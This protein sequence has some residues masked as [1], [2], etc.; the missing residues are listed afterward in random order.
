MATTFYFPSDSWK[1]APISPSRHSSWDVSRPDFFR[2]RPWSTATSESFARPSLG[3]SDGNGG[4]YAGSNP[5]QECAQQWVWGPI[6][7]A[8]V[9]SQTMTVGFMGRH[10]TVWG[11]HWLRA[12]VWIAKPDGT[13][14]GTV[15]NATDNTL[16]ANLNSYPAFSYSSRFATGTSGLSTVNAL[17]GDYVVI[18]IGFENESGSTMNSYFQLGDGN[19]SNITSSDSGTNRNPFLTFGS[20]T[21]QLQLLAGTRFYLPSAGV[22]PL[23]SLA[24][25]SGWFT[26]PTPALRFPMYTTKQTTALTSQAESTG[27]A[28]KE[29]CVFQYVSEPIVGMTFA[30]DDFIRG[31]MRSQEQSISRNIF[32]ASIVYVVSNDGGTIRGTII[33]DSFGNSDLEWA[34]SLTARLFPWNGLA[35]TSVTAFDWDRIVYEVGYSTNASAAD[36][37]ATMNYGDDAAADISGPGDTGADNPWLDFGAVITFMNPVGNRLMMMGHGT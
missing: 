14:R 27:G 16:Y 37:T 10:D 5:Q 6:E 13:N 34:T 2:A 11:F 4:S 8:S 30:P 23:N 20:T 9:A 19:A 26:R 18:E 24:G 21:F 1:A 36:G 33:D 7:A 29:N 28:S 15:V 32:A 31:A 12:C 22:S 35:R 25:H 3:N 17:A